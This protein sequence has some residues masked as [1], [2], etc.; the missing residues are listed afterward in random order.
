LLVS[1]PVVGGLG[2]L[3]VDRKRLMCE[4]FHL[5]RVIVGVHCTWRTVISYYL[6]DF[7]KCPNST[8]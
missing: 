1:G 6:F 2:D 5:S 3:T 4:C 7:A 8:L